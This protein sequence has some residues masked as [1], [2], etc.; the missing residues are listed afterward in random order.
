MND[1][2]VHRI[3]AILCIIPL[4][5]SQVS[6]YPS[7]HVFASY[8]IYP[9]TILRTSSRF[10]YLCHSIAASITILHFLCLEILDAYACCTQRA[11][12]PVHILLNYCIRGDGDGVSLTRDIFCFYY[13]NHFALRISETSSQDVIWCSHPKF[14]DIESYLF[15][16]N[17]L[18]AVVSWVHEHVATGS[19]FLHTI[20][21]RWITDPHQ[22]IRV[23]LRVLFFDTWAMG[24]SEYQQSSGAGAT[25]CVGFDRWRWQHALVD[26]LPLRRC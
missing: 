5:S 7:T 9:S 2:Y 17:S 23:R 25:D 13:H 12:D 26:F 21:R 15:T 8:R 3:S 16:T 14:R 11:D 20:F 6:E 24:F 1:Q 18:R 4:I 19:L 22:N 10:S